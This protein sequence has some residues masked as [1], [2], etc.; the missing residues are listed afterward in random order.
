VKG[1]LPVVCFSE[2]PFSALHGFAARPTPDTQHP[3]YEFYG[4]AISKASGYRLGARPVIYLPDAEADWIPRDQKWR[5]VRFE[6]G[7]VDWR[8]EREWRSPNDVDLSQVGFY[9]LV[10]S[11]AEAQEV[12]QLG[13]PVKDNVLG[14]LP[15]EHL[16]DM[17]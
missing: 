11:A 16:S 9:V 5:H 14:A 3:G 4:I 8:H 12:V 17:L 6:H 13:G 1:S 15:M 2:I 10:W 7:Q